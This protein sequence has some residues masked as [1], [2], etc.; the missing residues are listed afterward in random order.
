MTCNLAGEAD[1]WHAVII[2]CS[3]SGDEIGSSRAAGYQTDTDLS[4]SSCVSIC[5]MD[6]CLFMTRQDDVNA[7]LAI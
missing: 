3:K 2:C 1:K 6:K 7:T 4:C 5:L